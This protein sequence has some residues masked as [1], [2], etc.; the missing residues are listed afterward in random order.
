MAINITQ[1]VEDV[2]KQVLDLNKNFINKSIDVIGQLKNGSPTEKI[3]NINQD[4]IADVFNG[5]MKLNLE[6]YSKLM[7][8]GFSVTNQLLSSQSQEQE[9]PSAFTLSGTGNPGT[10]IKMEFVLDN[11][12]EER[13]VCQLENAAFINIDDQTENPEISV[14]YSPQTFELDAGKSATIN[15]VCSISKKS[16]AGT[17]YT[18]AKVVGFEPAYFTIIVNVE[19][20]TAKNASENQPT[21]KRAAK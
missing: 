20:N 1:N 4:M 2:T 10:N 7:D 15:I 11:S 6:Y 18:H 17:Y 14:D 3:A 9:T 16:A 19:K 21:K 13:V 8:Y 5:M 12:K